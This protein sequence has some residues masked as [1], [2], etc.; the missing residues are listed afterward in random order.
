MFFA[1]LLIDVPRGYEEV[2]RRLECELRL[3]GEGLPAIPAGRAES[4]RGIR[5]AI[6]D[7]GKGLV[8]RRYVCLVI[9]L[10]R[11]GVIE[12]VVAS[13]ATAEAVDAFEI[14]FHVGLPLAFGPTVAT[15]L[16]TNGGVYGEG[17]GAILVRRIHI[18]L[19]SVT[20]DAHVILLV[21]V[22]EFEACESLLFHG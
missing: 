18:I 2:E 12:D 17:G 4:A 20:C 15:V 7:H 1:Q 9:H 3:V 6:E 10:V 19:E 8:G 5:K 14:G 16:E 11:R 21:E 13:D 22:I